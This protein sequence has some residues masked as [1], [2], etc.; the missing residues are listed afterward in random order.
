MLLASAAALGSASTQSPGASALVASGVDSIDN[1]YTG[2]LLA[3]ETPPGLASAQS[4]V[5]ALLAD[6]SFDAFAI[7]VTDGFHASGAPLV[8]AS[9]H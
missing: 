3:S 4:H 8:S 2:L 5:A 9:I 7:S 6:S 1:R